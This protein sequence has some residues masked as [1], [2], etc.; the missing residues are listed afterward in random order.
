MSR[1]LMVM[2]RATWFNWSGSLSERAAA[3]DRHG[4]GSPLAA[5]VG[6]LAHG[7]RVTEAE[8]QLGLTVQHC[9]RW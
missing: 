4:V 3:L 9:H 7:S 2:M 8:Q 1:L 6:W 5:A